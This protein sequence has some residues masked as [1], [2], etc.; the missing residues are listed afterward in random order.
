MLIITLG[1]FAAT[2]S[3]AGKTEFTLVLSN[4]L[5]IGN[6]LVLLAFFHAH[7]EG[8]LKKD[9][10]SMLLFSADHADQEFPKSLR[11]HC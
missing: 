1:D 8:E 3:G 9:K 4:P 10:Q 11:S 6:I 5:L 7:W 2:C